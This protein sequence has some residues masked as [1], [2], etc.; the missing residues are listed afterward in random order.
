MPI[1][2]PIQYD[3][4]AS[5][6]YHSLDKGSPENHYESIYARLNSDSFSDDDISFVFTDFSVSFFRNQEHVGDLV[7]VLKALCKIHV[8]KAQMDL[9]NL[10]KIKFSIST[11]HI[12]AEENTEFM[13]QLNSALSKDECFSNK[14]LQP[15]A[16][17]MSSERYASGLSLSLDPSLFQE[18]EE[19]FE[20]LRNA[21]NEKMWGSSVNEGFGSDGLSATERFIFK[22]R[23]KALDSGTCET[24]EQEGSD[25]TMADVTSMFSTMLAKENEKLFCRLMPQSPNAKKPVSVPGPS[26]ASNPSSPRLAEKSDDREKIS[27]CDS[28]SRLCDFVSSIFSSNDKGDSPSSHRKPKKPK[29]L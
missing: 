16:H 10:L 6:N 7:R 18:A 5:V 1:K 19:R 25:I 11:T 2:I 22:E 4:I 3:D 15:Y 17:L 23:L 12:V 28:L 8:K 21:E 13:A 9:E 14:K 20:A 29:R 27:C 26:T 24:S